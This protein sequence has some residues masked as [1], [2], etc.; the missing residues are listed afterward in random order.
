MWTRIGQITSPD[1][2]DSRLHSHMAVPIVEP[3]RGSIKRLYFSARDIQNR[4]RTFR[5][6][7]DLSR[8]QDGLISEP[9][10]VLDLGELGTF[11]DSGAMA[12]WLCIEGEARYLYYTGWN[13]GQTV[14]FRNAIGLAISLRDGPFE[15]IGLGP[16]MDRTIAEPHFVANPCVL[17]TDVC[18]SMW[19]LS[20]VEWTETLDG[21]RH[22][23]HIKH[24]SSRDGVVWAREGVVAIDFEDQ[25]E[26]AISRPS[27]L[28]LG[29][30]WWMWFSCRGKHYRIRSATSLDGVSWR[31]EA[32][33]FGLDANGFGLEQEM[34]EYLYLFVEE[35]VLYAA[36]NGDG[37]GRDGVLFARWNGH[38]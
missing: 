28:R 10:L 4:S 35:G 31:R 19:Y 38:F 3:Y 21:P 11:D 17:K 9:E 6:L 12:S 25:S 13:L 37:Y 7:F 33:S 14:P 22:R 2:S 1:S 34:V 18:W 26:F 23:Y 20:C 16:I 27:V 30:K 29:G 15:R 32:A 36:Y 5:A 8:L 24:A